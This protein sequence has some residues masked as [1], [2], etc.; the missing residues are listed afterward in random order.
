MDAHYEY[1]KLKLKRERK[2]TEIKSNL[3]I[4]SQIIQAL[5]RI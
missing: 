1:Y 4:L 5:R 3:N 2:K